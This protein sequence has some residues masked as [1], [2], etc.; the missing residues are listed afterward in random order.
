LALSVGRK[1]E[2]SGT[3]A[4]VEEDL[5][6]G[7]SKVQSAAS[8]LIPRSRFWNG[9][10]EAGVHDIGELSFPQGAVNWALSAL[11]DDETGMVQHLHSRLGAG[12][13]QQICDC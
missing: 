2:V 7:V 1:N 12:H 11:K 3:A 9:E 10:L 5:Y 4:A 13:Q 8:D 6:F